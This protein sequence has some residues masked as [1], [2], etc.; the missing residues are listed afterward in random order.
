LDSYNRAGDKASSNF[1]QRHILNLSYV[2][3]L[4]FFSKSS[5]LTK[6]FLGG[7]QWSGITTFQSGVPFNI[8][9]AIFPDNAGSG[10]GVDGRSSNSRPDLVGNA[11]SAPCQTAAGAGPFLFNECAFA[12]PQGLTFGNAGRNLLNLPFRTNFDMGIFKHFAIKE[13]KAIEFRWETFNIFNHTQFSAVRGG[14]D[15]PNSATFLRA[16]KTHDPRI[17]QFGLKVLF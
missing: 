16:Y 3:D 17:M 15:G 5:G 10:N 7:W 13:S 12:A 11:H 4:P 2:Y 9:Y 1:D 14:F 6:T 8:S